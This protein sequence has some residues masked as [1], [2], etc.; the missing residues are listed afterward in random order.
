[1]KIS[2]SLLLKLALPNSGV[3]LNLFPIFQNMEVILSSNLSMHTTDNLDSHNKA[4]YDLSLSLARPFLREPELRLLKFSLSLHVFAPK[5]QS[6][7][8]IA[9]EWTE[10]SRC[11]SFFEVNGHAS[12]NIEELDSLLTTSVNRFLI[13]EIF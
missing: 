12:C 5:I 1:M 13:S 6:F 10:S 8:Q 9:E 4:G 2:A 7:Q 3:L 11:E